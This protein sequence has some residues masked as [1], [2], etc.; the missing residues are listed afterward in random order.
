MEFSVT[1]SQV[2]LLQIYYHEISRLGKILRFGSIFFFLFFFHELLGVYNRVSVSGCPL[3]TLLDR[4]LRVLK[5]TFVISLY[6]LYSRSSV[7]CSAV[8]TVSK[9]SH[10]WQVLTGRKSHSQLILLF[11]F[12][13]S[14]LCQ[15]FTC[16][17]SICQ[18]AF[19]QPSYLWQNLT[20]RNS[21]IQDPFFFLFS[22]SFIC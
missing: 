6:L 12:S 19:S 10:L 4:H 5:V 7:N 3:F 11:L 1:A 21:H 2:K 14:F 20:D 9:H 15:S 17:P 22:F 8:N 16:Q 18:H 13:L